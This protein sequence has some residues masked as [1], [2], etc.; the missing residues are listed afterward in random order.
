ML[1]DII[2]DDSA[3]SPEIPTEHGWMIL[4]GESVVDKGKSIT[5]DGNT[6]G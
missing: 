4:D 5:L 2:D 6:I 1:D 3:V